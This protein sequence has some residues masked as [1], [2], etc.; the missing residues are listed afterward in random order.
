L[1][2]ERHGRLVS[3]YTPH[4]LMPH[5]GLANTVEHRKHW[6]SSCTQRYDLP[7]RPSCS[8][9][10]CCSAFCCCCRP[11][12]DS[13]HVACQASRVSLLPGLLV[14]PYFV[15][16]FCCLCQVNIPLDCWA[17]LL[18][19]LAAGCLCR[20]LAAVGHSRVQGVRRKVCRLAKPYQVPGYCAA[21][22][23]GNACL[24]P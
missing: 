23:Q 7:R 21:A 2:N 19:L 24:H 12:V 1:H 22:I 6:A 14:L 11:S 9:C 3:L 15:I 4:H 16:H 13:P 10:C 5:P 18:L 8:C 20:R 17:L